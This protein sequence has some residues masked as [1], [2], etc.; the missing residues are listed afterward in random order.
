VATYVFDLLAADD[1]RALLGEPHRLLEPTGRLAVVGLTRGTT[2]ASR[3]VSGRGVRSPCGWPGLLGG[4][5]PLELSELLDGSR[6]RVLSRE[7]VTSWAV[8]S[9]VLVAARLEAA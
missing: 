3:G 2:P 8:P 5:R 7:I 4:C 9:D 6:W 1:A